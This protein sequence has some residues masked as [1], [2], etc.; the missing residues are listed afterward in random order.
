M[1]SRSSTLYSKALATL[2]LVTLFAGCGAPDSPTPEGVTS[3]SSF[4]Q[5]LGGLKFRRDKL[6][7]G[8]SRL[9]ADRKAVLARLQ[10]AGVNSVEDLA[11]HPDWRIHAH[12]L[13]D[14]V[15]RTATLKK[16]VAAYDQAITRMEVVLRKENRDARLRGSSLTVNDFNELSQITHELDEQLKR[17]SNTTGFEDLEFQIL[18]E[19]QL[20]KSKSHEGN[21]R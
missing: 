17:D 18:L 5:Q 3:Q 20:H 21:E 10:E 13:K 11:E 6:R 19:Q 9:E 2:V 7:L 1:R 14:V 15:G 4:H 12:E 8:L 16:T